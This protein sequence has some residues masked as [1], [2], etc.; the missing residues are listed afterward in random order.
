MSSTDTNVPPTDDEKV[1]KDPNFLSFTTFVLSGIAAVLLYY[2]VGA[3]F[4]HYIQ[5]Y[6]KFR[7]RAT[8][9]DG[10]PY[11]KT[12]PYINPF[13]LTTA[14]KKYNEAH[15]PPIANPE[16]RML[17]I[18]FLNWLTKT[19]IHGIS[20]TRR[21][22]D[23][24]FEYSGFIYKDL[25]EFIQPFIIIAAPFISFAMFVGTFFLGFGNTMI[26]A[27]ENIGLVIP[28]F[29]ELIILALPLLIPLCVYPGFLICS[30]FAASSGVAWTS[31]ILLAS[32]FVY[33]PLMDPITRKS[34]ID[35]M[36]S[37]QYLIILTCFIYTT[38]NAFIHLD[39]TYG[40][41][42]LG[43]TLAALGVFIGMR[44]L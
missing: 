26:G 27:I 34:I 22:G 16:E 44:I 40:Y 41:G 5:Y 11:T 25:P 6:T 32:L 21:I 12:F 2:F 4:M 18:R 30:A 24:F 15:K 31:I 39:K 28:D 8:K 1:N 36:I 29:F 23:K 37:S 7:M 9:A 14:Q 3:T 17:P 13:N 19:I 38:A 43:A 35:K 33:Y 20:S 10:E 42:C